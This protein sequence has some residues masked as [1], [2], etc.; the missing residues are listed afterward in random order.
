MDKRRKKSCV[1]RQ[2]DDPF[3]SSYALDGA[4]TVMLTISQKP[5][6]RNSSTP[7]STTA[8]Y[9]DDLRPIL[10]QV[11]DKLDALS[12]QMKNCIEAVT[13]ISCI[14][15]VTQ[16]SC[17]DAEAKIAEADEPDFLEF[18][19]MTYSLSGFASN[20]EYPPRR[21]LKRS[22]GPRFSLGPRCSQVMINAV[23]EKLQ[24]GRSNSVLPADY[25]L[26]HDR[27]SSC[28]SLATLDMDAKMLSLKQ[29]GKILQRVWQFIEP[30]HGSRTCFALTWPVLVLFSV[31][32]A[33]FQTAFP[34]QE[35][36]L[37]LFSIDVSFDILFSL[38]VF[39]RFAAFPDRRYFFVSPYN[40]VDVI[41]GP[42]HGV[43]RLLCYVLDHRPSAMT[44]A[45]EGCVPVLRLLKI[46]RRFEQIHL[47]TT[48]FQISL[49][50]MP[51][52][53]FTWSVLVL[54]FSALLYMVESETKDVSTLPD[55]IW[56]TLISASTV[57]Y[58]DVVP[59]TFLGRIILGILI[60][61]FLC[62]TA[63]PIG[64]V[65]DAF[66][67]VWRD[68]DRLLLMKRTRDKLLEYGF[69]AAEIPALFF[70]FDA[71]RDGLLSLPEFREL[72]SSMQLGV[73]DERVVRLFAT[74]DTDGDG[75]ISDTEFVK[76]LFPYDY[77]TIYA[78]LPDEDDTN[79]HDEY[80]DTR[81]RSS[82]D[83]GGRPENPTCQSTRSNSLMSKT[84]VESKT[85]THSDERRSARPDENVDRLK[86]STIQAL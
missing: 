38:E 30:P 47:L 50:V 80:P 26:T 20:P 54:F 32:L 64:I 85:S 3:A 19:S 46:L 68:R 5:S 81:L 25:R 82:R 74:F 86:S 79:D 39:V 10:S 84:S 45:L 4:D 16:P 41:A 28:S 44:L 55:A 69:S 42:L 6:D 48:A 72:V 58:G 57:G 67:E 31:G 43:A 17:I 22:V 27:P 49:E 75:A 77:K 24:L 66:S 2:P 9:N 23:S 34:L 12:V 52:L 71:D 70:V 13:Q 73:E 8:A 61:T 36:D 59:E 15:A 62:Y 51:V 1:A 63:I 78:N 29:R 40:I 65:G 7:R 37:M 21:S 53:F 18:E 11:N 83:S 76:I 14:G 33:L 56:L 60:L 35:Y